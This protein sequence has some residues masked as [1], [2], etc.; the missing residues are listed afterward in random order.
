MIYLLILWLRI[1]LAR[2]SEI[3]QYRYLRGDLIIRSQ[4]QSQNIRL[5]FTTEDTSDASLS[6]HI[7]TTRLMDTIHSSRYDHTPL[8]SMIFSTADRSYIV[9]TALTAQQSS[10]L[11]ILPTALPSYIDPQ[12]AIVYKA[13]PGYKFRDMHQIKYSGTLTHYLCTIQYDTAS[14][15]ATLSVVSLES[16]E[17]VSSIDVEL[18]VGGV[19]SV[20]PKI[21]SFYNHTTRTYKIIVYDHSTTDNRMC[22]SLRSMSTGS[23]R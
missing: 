15:Q 7:S 13:K 1:D 17:T 11:H 21:S 4:P 12:Q 5:S 2:S 6:P 8:Q 23:T 10:S 9:H 16:F 20:D 14:H 18:D 22:S 19:V 3:Q